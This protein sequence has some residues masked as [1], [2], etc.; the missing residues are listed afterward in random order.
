MVPNIEPPFTQFP[1]ANA[2]IVAKDKSNDYETYLILSVTLDCDND[3]CDYSYGFSLHDKDF[4]KVKPY[5][6]LKSEVDKYLPLELKG[7]I[8]QL[9]HDMT[10]NLIKR[11]QPKI[12]K[13]EA[14]EKLNNDSLKRYNEITN[15]LINELGYELLKSGINDGIN[16]WVFKK[17]NGEEI[18]LNER[19]INT[20]E[21]SN[22]E[23]RVIKMNKLFE[24]DLSPENLKKKLTGAN[25][26][27]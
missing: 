26:S 25:I 27:S 9:I 4:N 22:I 8:R 18:S 15:L 1:N 23:K 17:L 12:I 16:Y 14:M 13:R 5:M 10:K 3:V 19:N 20:F 24:T 2:I 21:L 11:L 6:Y 7:E